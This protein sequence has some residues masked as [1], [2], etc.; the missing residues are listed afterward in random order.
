MWIPSLISSYDKVLYKECLHKHELL[1]IEKD[2]MAYTNVIDSD[3]LEY[4]C[5]LIKV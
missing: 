3:Q 4:M 5:S 1:Q 2:L